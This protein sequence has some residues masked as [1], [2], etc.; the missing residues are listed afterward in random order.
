MV[1]LPQR[2]VDGGVV[3]MIVGVVVVVTA[4]VVV[5]DVVV[6][7]VLVVGLICVCRVRGD[8]WLLLL[9]LLPLL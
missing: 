2:C 9:R 8:L 1:S 6:Y 7:G 4:V 5:V 3:V